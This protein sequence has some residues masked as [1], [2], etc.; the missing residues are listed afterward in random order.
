MLIGDPELQSYTDLI[1][2]FLKAD[3]ANDINVFFIKDLL[4]TITRFE[5]IFSD[6]IVISII[7]PKINVSI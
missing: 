4:D 6:E 1:L 5:E 7:S 3:P 2:L